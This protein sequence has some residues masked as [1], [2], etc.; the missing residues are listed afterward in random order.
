ML[1]FTLKINHTDVVLS[2][3]QLEA[4]IAALGPGPLE[5]INS[6]W[7]GKDKGENNSGYTHALEYKKVS[8]VVCPRVLPITEHNALKFFT[9][10]QSV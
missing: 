1:R 9:A 7:V 5:I 2:G 10:H 6:T 4:I 8:E 3:E